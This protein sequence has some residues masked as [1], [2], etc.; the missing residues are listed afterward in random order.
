MQNQFLKPAIALSLVLAS[1]AGCTFT[2]GIGTE[3]AATPPRIVADQADPKKLIWDNPGAFGPVPQ[4]ELARGEK[5]C[6]ALDKD[7]LKFYPKGY[8][9][10]AENF[11]GK[12]FAGGGF[13]CVAK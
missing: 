8:H 6:S 10:R 2:P 1:L 11:Q 13:Y 7:N 3:P 12:P 5:S 4:S 9:P